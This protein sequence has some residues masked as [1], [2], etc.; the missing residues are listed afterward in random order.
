METLNND[1]YFSPEMD[2]YYV[3]HSQFLDFIGT[4]GKRGCEA[5][6]LAKLNGLYNEDDNIALLMG[7]YV[8]SYFEGTLGDFIRKNADSILSTRGASKGQLKA[9]FRQCDAMIKRAE[10]DFTF[11]RFMSGEKQR[12]FV[13]DINGV[14]V[15][16]KVDS[17]H[18]DKIVD[19]KTVKSVSESFYVK[20]IGGRMSFVEYWGYPVQAAMYQHVVWQNTGKKLPFYLACISKDKSSTGF[21]PRLAVIE[22]SQ[23]MIDDAYTQVFMNIK[24]VQALKKREIM[25]LA[26]GHCDFCA[27]TQPIDE[28]VQADELLERMADI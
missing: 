16:I 21:H 10:Q 4:P 18:D 8:D 20:D 27:D 13:G 5:R 3:G 2:R 6:A 24:K 23:K 9:D 7:S 19:L 14:P 15:K 22:I 17:Y 25:P 1:N 28:I 11:M 12:V 26:C